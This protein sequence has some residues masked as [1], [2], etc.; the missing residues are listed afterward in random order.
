MYRCRIGGS[1]RC[2]AQEATVHPWL[3]TS[4]GAPSVELDRGIL[5]GLKAFSRS[6]EAWPKDPGCLEFLEKG[7]RKIDRNL[8]SGMT[9]GEGSARA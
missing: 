2:F 3:A 9:P 4:E 5:D 7:T 1:T 6:N 8:S